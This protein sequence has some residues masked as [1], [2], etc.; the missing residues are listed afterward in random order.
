MHA[1]TQRKIS[2]GKHDRK[3]Q[4]N[5]LD[6]GVVYTTSQLEPDPCE[7]FSFY[8]APSEKV[9]VVTMANHYY[10]YIIIII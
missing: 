1:H 3:A 10:Y 2:E 5:E 6:K 4:E 9:S 8:L 7:S